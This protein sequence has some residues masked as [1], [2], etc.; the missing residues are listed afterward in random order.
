LSQDASKSIFDLLK[1]LGADKSEFRV[2]DTGLELI[3]S[4]VQHAI[5]AQGRPA[6]LVPLA[7]DELD[8]IDAE[9]KAVTL[10]TFELSSGGS[11]VRYLVVRCELAAL[12]PQFSLLT[13]DMLR[14]LSAVPREP[15]RACLMTLERWRALLEPANELLLSVTAQLGLIAELHVLERLAEVGFDAVVNL[16]TGPDAS[17]HDFTGATCAIE[18]KA[19]TGRD[20][21]EVG[22][23]GDRQLDDPLVGQLY[24]F[25]EQFET[26][27]A[28]ES[29]VEVVDRMLTLS[30]GSQTLLSKLGQVG[31]RVDDGPAYVDTRFSLVRRK[32]LLVDAAFPRIV[33]GSMKDPRVLDLLKKVQYSV[34][35]GPMASIVTDD[36]A[37]TAAASLL[38]G[39]E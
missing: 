1:R 5:D 30:H 18:V 14:V 7:V 26:S 34:D 19:T 32:L 8:V 29:V 33:R 28:G 17:R 23:H 24:L 21:F 4:P 36:R 9:S 38:R 22:I 31:Y 20:S 35:V 3:G 37:L 39:A 27:P 16:W 15:G 13:D 25:A 11:T 12:E 6:L 10:R 2:R